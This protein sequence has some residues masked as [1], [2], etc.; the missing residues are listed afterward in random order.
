MDVGELN[1]ISTT[2]LISNPQDSLENDNP[3]TKSFRK[4]KSPKNTLS[5]VVNLG[6]AVVGSALAIRCVN[7]IGILLTGVAMT[8]Y[9]SS[10]KVAGVA[11]GVAFVLFLVSGGGGAVLGRK[12]AQRLNP[13][14]MQNPKVKEKS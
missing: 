6:G 5:K 4:A 9:S 2:P 1:N 3:K 8:S 10:K 11:Y 12:V 7:P 14:Y 13:Y